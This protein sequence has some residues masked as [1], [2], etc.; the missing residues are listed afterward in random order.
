MSPPLIPH[1]IG[2]EDRKIDGPAGCQKT[3]VGDLKNGRPLQ[4][5]SPDIPA[6]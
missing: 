6:F 1:W 5:G 2:E 4:A 3:G